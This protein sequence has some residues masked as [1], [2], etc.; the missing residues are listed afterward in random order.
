[1]IPSPSISRFPGILLLPVILLGIAFIVLAGSSEPALA[2]SKPDQGHLQSTPGPINFVPMSD[3]QCLE[4]HANENMILPLPS[5]EELSLEVD[6]I[7][8]RTSVHGRLG[9]ACVQCHTDITGFPHPEQNFQDTRDVTIYMSQACAT[10]HEEPTKEYHAG[11]HSSLLEEGNKDSATCADCH[12]AHTI[13]EFSNLRT[14]IAS[15]C[16]QCH[17]EI[18][19]I[20]HASVHGEALIDDFNADVPACS[21]CH[22]NHNN[23][24]PTQEGF[25]LASPQICA[26]CH[27]NE[28]MMAKYGI[29]TNVFDTYFADFH[30]TT[31]LIFEKTTPDQETNKPVC[32]DCHGVHDIKSPDNVGSTVIKQNLLATCQRCHP[33]AT[34]NFSDSWLSHYKPDLE[35]HPIVYLVDLFYQF[36]IPGT[37]GIMAL[38]VV[39]DFWRTRI[40]N[41]KG[42]EQ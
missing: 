20:Y 26:K 6:R 38:F 35:H 41:P 36:F 2:E 14:R 40:Y 18:Y 29:N 25:H 8:Y 39:T 15:A 37:L 30:G 17:S 31:V 23:S 42:E 10:C 12:G 19:N 9:Y 34:P 27:T 1:M 16:E 28:T 4:C 21:D 3:D 32:I 7:E 33:D 5:G 13:R 11:T 24:G 22:G